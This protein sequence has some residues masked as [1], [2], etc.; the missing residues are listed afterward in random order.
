MYMGA[1]ALSAN[2]SA[3][4]SSVPALVEPLQKRHSV[5][6]LIVYDFSPVLC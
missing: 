4:M 2:L 1:L 3:Q 6:P 5:L